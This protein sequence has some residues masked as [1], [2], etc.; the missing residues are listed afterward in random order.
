MASSRVELIRSI[1]DSP[2]SE[3]DAVAMFDAGRAAS[4]N[5]DTWDQED[6]RRFLV[7]LRVAFDCEPV[8]PDE[9]VEAALRELQLD[10]N[11]Q[12]RISK[13]EWKSFFLYLLDSPL[14]HLES[15]A[16]RSLP[17]TTGG[18][19]FPPDHTVVVTITSD[20]NVSSITKSSL[21]SALKQSAG[22]PASSFQ[23]A[24]CGNTI[25]ALAVF[26]TPGSVENVLQKKLDGIDVDRVVL[27]RYESGS[28][29]PSWA[30]PATSS[31][32]NKNPGL[33]AKALAST[34]LFGTLVTS[35]AKA[36]DERMGISTTAKSAINATTKAVTETDE[37]LG[38]SRSVKGA[39][40]QVD[41]KLHI[42]ET[43]AVASKKSQEAVNQV[44][45][46]STAQTAMGFVGGL[47]GKVKQAADGLKAE[48]EAALEAKRAE[49]H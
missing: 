4:N 2:V 35:Q 45:Q 32:S 44:K 31:P 39:A 11:E 37:K 27:S 20:N 14:V 26:E 7:E 29:F 48:T 18:P 36:L 19:L 12:G 9:C 13:M 23:F 41:T 30:V 3:D 43:A 22:E 1:R 40:S 49:N 33:V 21:Q 38:I 16:F 28:V 6:L 34:V 42:T 24:Q 17:R 46:T 5:S 10:A 15:T 25:A 47:L 8:V